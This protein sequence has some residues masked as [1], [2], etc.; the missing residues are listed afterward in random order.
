MYW[1]VYDL[2]TLLEGLTYG[3][4]FVFHFRHF[5]PKA[6]ASRRRNESAGT[7]DSQERF[8]DGTFLML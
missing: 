7:G 4:L 6:Q 2:V 1:V 5:R 3:A 8:D